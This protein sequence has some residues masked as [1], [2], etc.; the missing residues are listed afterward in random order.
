MRV[1]LI[2]ES[3]ACLEVPEAAWQHIA[4]VKGQR[5]DV[6]DA[7][8]QLSLPMLSEKLLRTLVSLLAQHAH[9]QPVPDNWAQL[10]SRELTEADVDAFKLLS[11][12]ELISLANAAS[13]MG[14]QLLLNCVAKW[15]AQ[16]LYDKEMPAIQDY[17]GVHMEL[18]DEHR[19]HLR[20]VY[21]AAFD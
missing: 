2:V 20:N 4:Y 14:C 9:D 6:G 19:A 18:T 3:N 7:D 12:M 16:E 1:E 11:G 8:I 15:L 10:P 13:M 21:P 5:E 17:F